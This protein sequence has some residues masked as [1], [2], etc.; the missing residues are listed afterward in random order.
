MCFC[1]RE[2]QNLLLLV[3]IRMILSWISFS[4]CHPEVSADPWLYWHCS[5]WERDRC[6]WKERTDT[7]M[8]EAP[9]REAFGSSIVIDIHSVALF[10]V[11]NWPKQANVWI[12]PQVSIPNWRWFSLARTWFQFP[13]PK[14]ETPLPSYLFLSQPAFREF[15]QRYMDICA[16]AV[17]GYFIVQKS[18]KIRDE[19]A[20]YHSTLFAG[21]KRRKLSPCTQGNS[22]WVGRQ[23]PPHETPSKPSLSSMSLCKV[24]QHLS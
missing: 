2:T 16:H 9:G 22:T 14:Q 5:R 7:A 4:Y 13:F 20:F 18:N 12:W 15:K 1:S 8:G 11:G 21:P 6:F 10:F 23:V 24:V 17:L 3:P 19:I